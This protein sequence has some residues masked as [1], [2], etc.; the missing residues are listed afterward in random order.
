MDSQ[1][2]VAETDVD[3]DDVEGDTGA[4]SPRSYGST[5][6][7]SVLPPAAFD[8]E[9]PSPQPLIVQADVNL[10]NMADLSLPVSSTGEYA[11][12]HTRRFQV[13][14]PSSPWYG[15]GQYDECAETQKDEPEE[16]DETVLQ[17]LLLAR[18]DELREKLQNSSIVKP[19]LSFANAN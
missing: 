6:S 8:V 11:G 15:I 10:E 19:W 7:P 3:G 4:A 2:D 1:R 14:G 13:F 16:D 17:H 18:R 5:Q 12:P 9:F